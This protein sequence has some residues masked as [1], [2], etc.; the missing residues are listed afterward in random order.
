VS[1]TAHA[2]ALAKASVEPPTD[3]SASLQVR[4][5]WL[6]ALRLVVLTLFL[7]VTGTV[8]M[9]GLA[10]GGFSS[11]LIL[12]TVAAAY[13][14]AALYAVL[15]RLGR[16]LRVVTFAQLVTDQ[17]T[18]T[19]IVY[20]SGGVASGATSLYGLTCLS[21]AIL[22]GLSGALTA[23]LAAVVA[24]GALCVGFGLRWIAPPPDQAFDAYL[25]RWPEMTYP[26]FVNVLGL[27]VVALLASYL[28]ER[29]RTTGGRLVAATARADE[30]E[31]LAMLGRLAAALAH[32]IRNPLGA[33]A[34]SVE[35]LRTGNTLS[36]EDQKL[37]E[38]VERETSRLN[39]LVGDMLDLSR[40]RAPVRVEHDLAATAREVV[41]LASR[42]GRG[43]DVF[44]R[45]AGP[46]SVLVWAD[47]AQMRQVMWNLV[48]N[49]A[50]ASR[51]GESVEVRLSEEAD[52]H[53]LAVVDTGA[54]ISPEAQS[55]MFSAFFT[56]RTHGVGIGLAVVKRVV[57][58]HGFS[59]E[60]ESDAGRG[61]TFRV[62]ML[63]RAA[64]ES[65]PREMW[66]GG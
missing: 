8:Y 32:E 5:A 63:K 40:P 49:A 35:L 6:T 24:Y 55:R 21:G 20:V 36:E 3:A 11:K 45:Y 53:V 12:F 50:Q 25:T 26:A 60:V 19:I 47:A 13:S 57:E 34:G 66:S 22:L 44:I 16:H 14:G 28:A 42:A 56:T 31:Q 65:A 58:A 7:I 18:W 54:G 17:L 1:A 37:C 51:P 29:L 59:I 52:A 38:L 64:S 39:D 43:G 41:T 48:R 46:D 27:V 23:A 62:R 15:L 33:I 61:T 10:S 2:L 9:G 30:A 4:L